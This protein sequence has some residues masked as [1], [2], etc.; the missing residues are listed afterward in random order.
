VIRRLI[1][2]LLMVLLF[3]AAGLM[4]AIFIFRRPTP[5]EFQQATA[6]EPV[7]FPRD[8]AAHFKARTDWWYYTG[9]LTGQDGREY[10]F[11]LVF[12]RSYVPPAVRIA[13]ALP[14]NWVSN[15]IYFAH[16]ALSDQQ[17]QEHTFFEQV[18][19]PHFWDAGAR[20]DRFE[21][22]NGD[23]RAWGDGIQHHL[24]ADG[25][26]YRLRLDLET[27]KAPVLHGPEGKGVIEMGQAGTS[28]YYSRADL[29]GAGLLYIDGQY[30]AVL[31]STWMD[32]QWGSWDLHQG[33]D[34]WDWFSLR[35]DDGSRVMLFNFRDELGSLQP[36]SS[37]T[38]ITPEGTVQ[39]LE[40]DDYLVYML[41][42]WTSPQTGGTY[43]VAW[44]IIIP[45][46][47]FQA[48]VEATFPEQELPIHFGPV[49]WEGTVTVT[50]DGTPSGR[51]F[52]ELTGY[53]PEDDH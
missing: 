20:A 8:E 50:E 45:G 26:R 12:F 53:A 22:W 2:I 46:Q 29:E 28:Y 9:F 41:D 7:H 13:N 42:Q 49:Y 1:L 52:V 51:G 19:F 33:F 39:H 24:R 18:S 36:Q 43:P 32:H 10:G 47:G 38:W 40:S 30:Q 17:T 15:P 44:Q 5:L 23:W 16:F 48:T 25:G 21:V 37:G 31:A 35:L 34:G 3:L 14:L 6:N 27:I 4:T 11:E